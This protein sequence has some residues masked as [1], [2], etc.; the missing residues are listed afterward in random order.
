MLNGRPI[1]SPAGA[2]GLMQLMPGTYDDMRA[3]F[4]FGPDPYD[5]HDNILAGAA[6][7]RTMY[8][9]YGY[10][11]LFAAYQA[12]PKRLDEHLFSGKELPQSTRDYVGKIVPGAEIAI[13]SETAQG[14][15]SLLTFASRS[16]ASDADMAPNMLF[17][18]RNGE[19]YAPNPVAIT[20]T[21]TPDSLASSETL[22]S[23]TARSLFIPVSR[24]VP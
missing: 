13:S 7:L 14:K 8:R 4:G 16:Q 11:H 19:A 24:A 5:P 12:G 21:Q 23:K 20:V 9:R 3:Q 17:F 6:Y 22:I 1:T 10:P 2:M 15:K 18:V